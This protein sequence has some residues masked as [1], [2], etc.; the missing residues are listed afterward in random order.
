MRSL[1]FT[2]SYDEGATVSNK[3]DV[4]GI[5]DNLPEKY[6]KQSNNTLRTLVFGYA[7]HPKEAKSKL[8]PCRNLVASI[9]SVYIGKNKEMLTVASHLHNAFNIAVKTLGNDKEVIIIEGLGIDAT[10]E[11]TETLINN[12]YGIIKNEAKRYYDISD[13]IVIA[14]LVNNADISIFNNHC[15]NVNYSYKL[16]ESKDCILMY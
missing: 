14:W 6:H 5:R 16:I 15:S 1:Y 10:E 7:V 8:F 3:G 11:E 2:T 12:L 13:D 4:K 9:S